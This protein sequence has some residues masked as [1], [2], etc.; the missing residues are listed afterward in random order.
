MKLFFPVVLA[1]AWVAL[2]GMTLTDF[3]GF[4]SATAP[5]VAA[6]QPRSGQPRGALARREGRA[7]PRLERACP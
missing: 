7:G 3:A 5:C 4:A 6:A 2:V 1:V